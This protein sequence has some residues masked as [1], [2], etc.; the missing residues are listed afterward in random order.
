MVPCKAAGNSGRDMVV[1]VVCCSLEPSSSD[2]CVLE[3]V[4]EFSP[5]IGE[6]DCAVLFE[7]VVLPFQAVEDWDFIDRH[8]RSSQSS[9]L[10]N[11]TTTFHSS[12]RRDRK[13]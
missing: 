13:K 1:V 11:N 5:N 10:L 8:R 3:L 2:I 7:Y 12:R 4:R 9:L 6:D